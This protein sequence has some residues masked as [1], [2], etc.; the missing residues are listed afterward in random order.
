MKKMFKYIN[1]EL[2][3]DRL[4]MPYIF[5][6]TNKKMKKYGGE[7][8][9]GLCAYGDENYFIALNKNLTPKDLF[10]TLVHEL[11]H[12]DVE[13]RFNHSGH[14]KPFLKMCRKAIDIFYPEML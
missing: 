10:D 12:I 3:D 4:D 2:F 14:G 6:Y 9:A 7:P 11:I 13:T 1:R 8:V 5:I